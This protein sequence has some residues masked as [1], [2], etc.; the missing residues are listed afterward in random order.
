MGRKKIVF[1]SYVSVRVGE[2]LSYV[3]PSFVDICNLLPM[4]P[5]W[6]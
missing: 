5:K 1:V 6:A 4:M 2:N 3:V